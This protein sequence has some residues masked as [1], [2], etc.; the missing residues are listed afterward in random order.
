MN[1]QQQTAVSRAEAIKRLIDL[2][3]DDWQR[4]LGEERARVGLPVA[5]AYEAL[6]EENRR[7]RQRLAELTETAA[8]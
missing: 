4:I 5:V 1:R 8:R 7:L 2:H 6:V 3:N